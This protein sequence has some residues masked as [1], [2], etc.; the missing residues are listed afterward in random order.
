[1][2]PTCEDCSSQRSPPGSKAVLFAQGWT[3]SK[4]GAWRCPPCSLD[5][6]FKRHLNAA[7]ALARLEGATAPAKPRPRRQG[8]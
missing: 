4:G 5:R 8:R 3:L 6:A 1:M 2:R 7:S